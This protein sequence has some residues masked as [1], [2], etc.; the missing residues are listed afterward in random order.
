[1]AKS[2]IAN[3]LNFDTLNEKTIEKSEE[4]LK[5]YEPV[6]TPALKAVSSKTGQI[7]K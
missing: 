3:L 7:S 2:I 5:K 6:L 4:L 1:M